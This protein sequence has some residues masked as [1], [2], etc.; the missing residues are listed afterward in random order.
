MM[1][2][3]TSAVLSKRRALLACCAVGAVMM[4]SP[5]MAA[6]FVLGSELPL[7]GKLARVGTGMSEGIAIAIDLANAKYAGQHHFSVQTIDDETNPAKA[8]AAVEKLA[9][10][11][12]VAITGGY[13]SNI[14]GPASEAAAKAGLVYMTSGGVA[15]EL[16]QRGLDSFFR[17]NNADGYGKAMVGLI[18]TMGAKSVA[19]LY[20]NKEA[21][22][23]MATYV[24][25][26]LTD[27]GIKITSHEFD[28]TTTDFKPI[29]N[30]VKLQDRPEVVA[31][32][33]YE[34][35]YIG[36]LRAGAVLKP[37]V[38]AMVGVW[39][40]ATAQMNKEFHDQVQGVYGTSPLPYP[41]VFKGGEAQDFA[42]AY[43]NKY[44]REPD[45]LQQFGYV[46][47]M[48]LID[49]IARAHDNDGKIEAGEI[50]RE[51]RATTTPTMIGDVTFDK[52][53]DNPNFTHRMGQHQGDRVELV[54]PANA[55]TAKMNY[56]AVPW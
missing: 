34:N 20:S 30:K 50:A 39:S 24:Q 3:F 35:D 15:P 18:E 22:A 13:G 21:T 7:T 4:A 47:T 45:Y 38:K 1:K 5:A 28:D 54:W 55:A 56:P 12:V 8:V 52:N 23:A 10:D 42:A 29:M 16:T 40:L 49:A 46:Q 37:D 14:I 11:H 41:V 6:E 2:R 51:L 32:I 27:K 9:S 43:M 31:M 36:I 19:I 48:L 33:G 53:G 44:N 17:I 26:A 25:K